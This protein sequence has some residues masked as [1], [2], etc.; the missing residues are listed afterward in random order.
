MAELRAIEGYVRAFNPLAAQRLA[1][2]LLTVGE[3]L[4]DLPLRGRMISHGRRELTIV[5]PYLL[6]Y[7]VDG[8]RVIVLEVRHGAREPD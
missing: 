4:R 5:W 1:I 3:S 8:D 2:R 6:R 7:R